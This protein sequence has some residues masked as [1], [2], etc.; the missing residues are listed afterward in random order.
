MLGNPYREQRTLRRLVM[1]VVLRH[2]LL[3]IADR[4]WDNLKHLE[5]PSVEQIVYR[6]GNPLRRLRYTL[7]TG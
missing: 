5:P 1:P 4:H 6:R 3:G 7:T 2:E